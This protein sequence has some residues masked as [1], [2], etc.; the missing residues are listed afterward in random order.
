MSDP[1]SDRRR[2][3]ES[4]VEERETKRVRIDVLDG[5]ESGEWVEAEE[6]WVRIHRRPRGDLFSPHDSQDGPKL[7][8]I[9]NRRESTVC[10]TDEGERRI[11]DRWR[12]K[13]TSQDLSQEWTGS[14]RFRKSW[15]E[16]ERTKRSPAEDDLS[17]DAKGDILD[18]R[19]T[20]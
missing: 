8:D 5:E 1:E 17:R 19:P 3:R 7:S 6:E 9:S 2:P 13:E 11:V 20:S 12:D 14:T 18:L 16:A 10:S 15:E 4:V